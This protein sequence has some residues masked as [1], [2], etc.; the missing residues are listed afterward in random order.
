[1][2]IPI[3]STITEMFHEW[4]IASDDDYKRMTIVI[5]I[6]NNKPITKFAVYIGDL[7][8]MMTGKWELAKERYNSITKR[9]APARKELTLIQKE[10]T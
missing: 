10:E 8:V 4:E 2:N 3:I 1:M 7:C 5:N 6:V 9:L